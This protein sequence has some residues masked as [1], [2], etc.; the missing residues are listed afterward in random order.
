MPRLTK[1]TPKYRHHKATG[2]AIVTIEGKDRYLG[3]W[4]SKASRVEYDRLICEWLARGRPDSP[5]ATVAE[6][7]VRELVAAFYT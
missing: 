3:P 4:K 6:I 7:T 2:Q 1:S 5:Q